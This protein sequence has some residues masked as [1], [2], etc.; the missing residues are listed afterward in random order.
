MSDE[1]NR[2]PDLSARKLIP[3]PH[4]SEATHT[5]ALCQ[6]DA[7][8]GPGACGAVPGGK[9]GVSRLS[10][11]VSKSRRSQQVRRPELSQLIARHGR[12][13]LSPTDLADF[14]LSRGFSKKKSVFVKKKVK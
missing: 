4:T 12:E 10:S 3:T 5:H 11:R 14:V 7:S 2:A 8:S 13:D 6:P 1:T 9:S